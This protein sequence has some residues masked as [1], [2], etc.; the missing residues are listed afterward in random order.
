MHTA[1]QTANTATFIIEQAST[2]Q[3]VK[4]TT[5]VQGSQ[6]DR[7]ANSLSVSTCIEGIQETAA[8]AEKLLVRNAHRKQR[9]HNLEDRTQAWKTRIQK[10]EDKHKQLTVELIAQ[11]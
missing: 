5:V 2:L 4:L 9:A 3:A 11:R 8:R 10:Y 6:Q 1:L 7:M